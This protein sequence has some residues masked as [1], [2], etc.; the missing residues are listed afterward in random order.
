[1]GGRRGGWPP[2]AGGGRRGRPGRPPPAPAPPN[3]AGPGRRGGPPPPPMTPI[4]AETIRR[5]KEA[6]DTQAR[7]LGMSR[8]TFLRSVSGAALM[9]LTLDAT[10]RAARAGAAGGRYLLHP[11]S[12]GGLDAARPRIPRDEP[13]FDGQG[14]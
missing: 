13:I 8:R 1:G 11:A 5:T 7:R 14:P 12:V 2:V 4:E 10:A 9:L 3:R 6:A